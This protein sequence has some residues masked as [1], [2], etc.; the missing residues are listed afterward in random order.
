MNAALEISSDKHTELKRYFYV[1][2]TLFI[3]TLISKMSISCYGL[4]H[5]HPNLILI[6]QMPHSILYGCNINIGTEYV[7]VSQITAWHLLCP[8]ADHKK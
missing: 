2:P 5:V 4:Q 6:Y 1:M 3:G 7:V 8:I